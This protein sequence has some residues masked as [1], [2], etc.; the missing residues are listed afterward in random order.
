MAILY[1]RLRLAASGAEPM[2]AR[3]LTKI[4][5]SNGGKPYNLITGAFVHAT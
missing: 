3:D 2:E 5:L 4:L 1:N